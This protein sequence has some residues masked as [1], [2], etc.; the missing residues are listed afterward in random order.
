MQGADLAACP[1][2]VFSKIYQELKLDYA[3]AAA[4]T[5]AAGLD[6]IDCPV[7]EGGEVLPERVG[8]DLPRY[9]DALAK[10]QKKI[11]LVTSGITSVASP[12]AE[13]V[14]RT[15]KGMGLKYYR[16]GFYKPAKPGGFEKQSR[17]VKG[18]LK[19]LAAVNQ[20]LGMCGLFQNH[21]GSLGGKL[22]E[23]YQLV[24]DFNPDHLGV[25][26]DIGHALVVH[27]EGWGEH[28]E[29]LKKH[30]RIIYIKDARIG[31]TWTPFGKGDIAKTDYFRRL[32]K[33]NYS[34]PISLHIEYD[35]SGGGA[36]DRASLLKA[37][38][39][40]TGVLKAWLQQ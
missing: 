2:A 27:G 17:E 14:L 32:K 26:F 7:R 23:L 37:L 19:D 3:A 24:A 40:S 29:R 35:W 30:I 10:H 31:G 11:L 34:A 22:D 15:S 36:K 1:I 4:L 6:G 5:A 38:K 33:L 20:Q 18:Q 25:A 13:T 9:A 21:G 12:N 16:L 8:E 28:F 39:E